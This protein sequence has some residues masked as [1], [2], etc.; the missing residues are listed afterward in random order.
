ML[1][2]LLLLSVKYD[3]AQKLTTHEVR[4]VVQGNKEKALDNTGT[5]YLVVDCD[6]I[7]LIIAL[8]GM[9]GMYKR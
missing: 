4:I 6:V 5:L 7:K 1:P 3:T 9:H 8:Q 2:I